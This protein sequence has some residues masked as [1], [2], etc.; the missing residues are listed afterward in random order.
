MEGLRDWGAG[1]TCQTLLLQ[2]LVQPCEGSGIDSVS[3]VMKMYMFRGACPSDLYT[4]QH[5][6]NSSNNLVARQIPT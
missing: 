5:H 6:L 2:K 3:E 4:E 1:G